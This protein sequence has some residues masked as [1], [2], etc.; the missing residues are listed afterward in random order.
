[1]GSEIDSG[2]NVSRRLS[3]IAMWLFPLALVSNPALAIGTIN[4]VN[5]AL[6]IGQGAAYGQLFNPSLDETRGRGA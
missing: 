5:L 1:L 6:L 2:R 4:I 3:K